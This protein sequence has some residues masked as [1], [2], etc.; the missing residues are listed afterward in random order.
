MGESQDLA[1]VWA[2]EALLHPSPVGPLADAG[3]MLAHVQ[4]LA[5]RE[6][7]RAPVLFH[8]WLRWTA[9]G[10]LRADPLEWLLLTLLERH[11][12]RVAA[13]L[14]TVMRR[15]SPSEV[16]LLHGHFGAD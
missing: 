1:F 10:N 12:V 7:E 8:L 15:V 5:D 14:G 9:E 3:E 16:R 11:S 6:V 2:L 4:R 13:D